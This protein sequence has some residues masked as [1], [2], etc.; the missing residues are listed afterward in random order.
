MANRRSRRGRRRQAQN[1]NWQTV[2][3]VVL[4]VF[5]LGGVVLIAWLWV[6]TERV[7]REPET[8]CPVAGPSA[9]TAIYV[10]TTDSVD[11][12]SRADILGRLEGLVED[13][14]P[15]ELVVAYRSASSRDGAAPIPPLLERCHPG[16]PETASRLT[17]NPRLIGKRLAEEFREPLEAVFRETLDAAPAESSPLMENLQAISVTLLSRRPYSD[18][19]RR[20]VLV[21]DLLQHSDNLSLYGDMPEYGSFTRTPRA[22]AL[23]SDLRDVEVEILFV[24]RRGYETDDHSMA[25][26]DFWSRWVADQGGRVGRVT[27]VT[28]LNPS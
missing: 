22:A 27:R 18:L 21:S 14:E 8:R 16:D 10:D 7:E 11:P 28:G 20:V 4:G 6:G 19:P 5:V 23:D 12:V 17:Q 3:F 15:D 25:L 1:E 13:T 9:V 2:G 24:Q 26:I